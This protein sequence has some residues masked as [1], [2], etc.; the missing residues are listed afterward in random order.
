M[1]DKRHEV[2]VIYFVPLIRVKCNIVNVEHHLLNLE[3]SL[4]PSDIR[5]R[6]NRRRARRTCSEN[7]QVKCSRWLIEEEREG[8]LVARN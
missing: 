5:K 3:L 2:L 6:W 7:P 4:R 8:S 1:S